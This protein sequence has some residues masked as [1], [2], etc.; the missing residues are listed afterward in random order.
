MFLTFNYHASKNLEAERQA[1]MKNS[2]P[3]SRKLRSPNF[4]QVC[5]PGF[6]RSEN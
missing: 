2:Q 5:P 3:S 4:R 6:G 1:K